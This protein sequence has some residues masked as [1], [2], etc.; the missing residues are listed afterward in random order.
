MKKI[1]FYASILFTFFISSCKK[2]QI[3]VKNT[4]LLSTSS[5]PKSF[6]PIIAK[7]TSTT[8]ITGFIFEG[9][10]R[11]NGVTLKVEPSLAL[12][13]ESDKSGKVWKFYLR[14]DVLWNDGKRFTADDVVFTFNNLIYNDKI[15]TSSRD[16][17]TIEGKKIKVVKIDDYTV[18]FILPEKFAPFLQLLGQEILPRHKLERAVI[19]GKF[20]SS[21][22]VNEKVENIVGTGPY[23]IKEY[24]PGEWIILKKNQYYWKRDKDGFTLPYIETIVFQIIP[25]PNMAILKFRTG[26]ID[27][28]SIRGQDYY[29]LK[30]LEKDKNFTIYDIGPS[31]GSEFLALNQNID[32]KIP[33]YKKEWFSDINFRKCIAYSIDRNSIIK[34]VY[35]GFGTPQYGPM[36]S[37]C[38]FFYNDKIKKYEYD[39]E[40]AKEYL[41]KSGFFWKGNMLYDKKGNRVEFTIITNSNN[42]E[43]VQIGNII[44]NDLEKLGMKVNLLPIDFNTL[45]NKLTI[46][47]DWEAVIIGLTGGIEPHGGK[48]VWHSKGQLHFWNFGNKRDYQSEKEIDQLFEK[49]TKYLEPDIR[50]KIY[51]KWQYI[52]TDNLPLIYTANSNV[53]YAVRNKFENLKIT[54]YGGVLHNIEEI[55]IKENGTI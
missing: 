37:S 53:I 45:V 47:K 27:I 17:F 49:G 42:S 21:W 6:N 1:I 2:E 34:N 13:W 25:D 20:T 14:K 28:I 22:G 16:I 30:P 26:E 41:I 44:Q 40:K 50:K 48:N 29:V 51:D 19:E 52:V 5:D 54:V 18:E 4:L 10:T 35:A 33:D 11:I 7:E 46:T 43:R 23:K 32:A 38:G 55:K 3:K 31:L 36:N 8:L 9:L 39:L 15:P 12:K 24:R